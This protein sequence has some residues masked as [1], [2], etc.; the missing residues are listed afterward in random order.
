MPEDTPT[1]EALVKENV[2]LHTKTVQLETALSARD[3]ELTEV[4]AQLAE[5]RCLMYGGSTSES[6]SRGS[7]HTPAKKKRKKQ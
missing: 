4:K 7:N 5:L 6:R 1:Y 2:A 3:L